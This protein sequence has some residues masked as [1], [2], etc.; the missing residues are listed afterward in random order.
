MSNLKT[1]IESLLLIS[2]KPLTSKR[3]ATVLKVKEGEVE[4]SV[5]ALIEEYDSSERG[6]EILRTGKQF[7]LVTA[8]TSAKVVSDFLKEEQTGELTRPSL[9]TLTIVVYRSPIRKS[10]IELIRGVNCSLILRNLLIRGLVEESRDQKTA[11]PIY[12][13][14]PEFLKWLGVKR[15][16]DLPDY[17]RLS[18]DEILKDLLKTEVEHE[19]NGKDNNSST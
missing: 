4:K 10:E 5:D 18:G 9:E 12:H 8:E 7:Q 11:E 3:I 19:G 13:V 16:E 2:N 14:T 1:S 15:V 6:M 17:K